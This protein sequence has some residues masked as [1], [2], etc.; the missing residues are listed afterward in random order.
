[1]KTLNLLAA[2]ALLTG[3]N[4]TLAT[5]FTC[6][7][8]C[9]QTYIRSITYDRRGYEIR[10]LEEVKLGPVVQEFG[11]NFPLEFGRKLMHKECAMRGYWWLEPA[12]LK[13]ADPNCV[14]NPNILDDQAP[15]AIVNYGQRS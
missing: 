11:K 6:K 9:F 4:Q 3:V 13:Q 1:M 5:G 15:Y 2:L 12:Q 7:S 8:E 10:H 14:E